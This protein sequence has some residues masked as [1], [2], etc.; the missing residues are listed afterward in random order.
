[1]TSRVFPN[2]PTSK[3]WELGCVCLVV[4]LGHELA[5]APN[6]RARV[7]QVLVFVSIYPG[8]I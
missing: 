7:T 4:V 3:R 8:A 5:V 1:M 6:E 2:I